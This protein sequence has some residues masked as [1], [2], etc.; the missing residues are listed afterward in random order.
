LIW[1]DEW[2]ARVEAFARNGGTVVFSARTGSRDG[3]NHVIRDAAPGKS[4]TALTGVA[5]EEFG[6]LAPLEGDGLFDL[7][8]RASP[9]RRKLPAESAR[10]RYTLKI[11]NHEMTAAHMYELLTLADD[12]TPV[13]TWSNRF[14]AGQPV[15]TSRKV[16]KGRV[17]YLGTYLTYDLVA[18]LSADLFA[19][20]AVAPLLPDLPAGVEVTLREAEGRKLL[21]VLNTTDERKTLSGIPPATALV[22]DGPVGDTLSLPAY[23]CAVLKLSN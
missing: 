8:G 18:V 19:Q 7:G 4:L 3:N 17:V 22:A 5:V 1:K 9:V 13:G 12:V 11:G 6:R 2:T 21:F 15:V 20:A 16:G 10:R 14:A 23:G